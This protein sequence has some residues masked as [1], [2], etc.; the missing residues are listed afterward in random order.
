M[1]YNFKN[2]PYF[3]H[4]N[5]KTPDELR[6]YMSQGSTDLG[7]FKYSLPASFQYKEE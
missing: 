4:M 5:T 1:K 2:S 6:Y 3:I 7:R